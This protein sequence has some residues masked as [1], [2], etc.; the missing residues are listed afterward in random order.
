MSINQA[1]L[2]LIKRFEGFR[3]DA[4]F[5]PAGKLTIGYG[6][7][8]SA[9][10]GI[11][12]RPGMRITEA[13]A[14]TYLLRTVDKFAATIRPMI[15]AP[16]NENQFGAMVSLAYNIG[17]GAFGRSSVL[18]RFNRGEIASAADAFRMWNKAG[19]KVLQGLVNRREEER[20][21]FLTPVATGKPVAVASPWAGLV[22]FISSLANLARKGA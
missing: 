14:E 12:P 7:T 4:Y 15:T 9:G 6:T 11:D 3:P 13:E 22:A 19:G 17:P 10:V 8:A 1:T 16:V 5:C 18:S 21:L 20:K 2:D